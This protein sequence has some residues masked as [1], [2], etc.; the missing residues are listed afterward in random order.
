MCDCRSCLPLCSPA[1]RFCCTWMRR[2]SSAPH[3]A[4][5][6]VPAA[7]GV[8]DRLVPAMMTEALQRLMPGSHMH[9]REGALRQYSPAADPWSL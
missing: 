9:L 1:L 6:P 8:E 2:P 3:I 4:C 5:E 7:H